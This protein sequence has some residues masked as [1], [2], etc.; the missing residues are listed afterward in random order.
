MIRRRLFRWFLKKNRFTEAL[1]WRGELV[2]PC[3]S[4]EL[5]AL[6]QVGLYET[7]VNTQR[8]D[9]GWRGGFVTAVSLAACGRGVEAAALARD[10]AAHN[11]L[12]KKQAAFADALAPFDPALALELIE[13]CQAPASLRAA[14]LLR[15]GKNGEAAQIVR[16]TLNRD[17]AERLPELS[18]YLSNAERGIPESRLSHLNAFLAAYSLAPLTLRDASLPPSPT[19]IRAAGACAPTRGPLVSVLMTAWCTGSRIEAAIT[20]LLE[21]SYRDIE[22]I[23][24]DDASNDD[25]GEVVKAMAA[26]DSRIV[27]LRLPCNVGTYVAKSIGLRHAS[28]EFVTCQDSDDW[29]HPMKIERQVRP[30]LENRKLVFSTSHWVRMTD[31]GEYHARPV[32]PLMRMNPASPL[33]RK[34]VV[35]KRAGAWDAVRT[36][37]DSE[38]AAR[39]KLVFGLGA[40]HRIAEPLTLGSHR[41]DS[42][43]NAAGTGYS[44]TGISPTRLAYWESWGKWHIKSLARLRKPRLPLDLLAKRRFP[45]PESIIV[46]RQDIETCLNFF[47]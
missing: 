44:T 6:Y 11:K 4:D 34:D 25:T 42:L 22:L 5:W 35:L 47:K 24:V 14:L 46:P 28:G 15:A 39:L 36:G 31:D 18:L 30:L 13:N 9:D 7:V 32:H 21:Q 19:N 43:M 2:G 37:A 23:V 1:A 20:S 10:L 45:A 27:Y 8:G 41:P 38:F 40:M 17:N 33:F 12:Q 29:A 3:S 26:K 16:E